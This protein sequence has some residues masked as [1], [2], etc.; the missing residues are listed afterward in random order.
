MENDELKGLYCRCNEVEEIMGKM[1]TIPTYFL[2]VLMILILIGFLLANYYFYE[3]QKI[4]TEITLT[5]EQEP[6]KIYSPL[7]GEIKKIFYT[8]NLHV[9]KGDTLLLISNDSE[10]VIIFAPYDAVVQN[11]R[12]PLKTISKG[13]AILGLIPQKKGKYFCYGFLTQDMKRKVRIGNVVYLSAESLFIGRGFISAIA[14]VSNEDDKYYY[15]VKIEESQ[16]LFK[17]LCIPQN[18][19]CNI[20][21]KE[22]TFMNDLF[23]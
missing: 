7:T 22:R 13:D 3:P 5:S 20:I 2:L 10:N 11:I 1:P 9:C 16:S 18:V 12:P 23:F 14:D 8:N 6:E 17:G 19:Q 4:Q 15:E 21:I